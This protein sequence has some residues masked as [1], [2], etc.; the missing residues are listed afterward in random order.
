[1]PIKLSE[2]RKGEIALLILK[3]DMRTKQLFL[4]PQDLKRKIGNAAEQLKV[5]G[6]SKE[7]LESLHEELIRNAVDDMF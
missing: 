4:N 6:V 7:E 2:E 5:D 3:R 1:M